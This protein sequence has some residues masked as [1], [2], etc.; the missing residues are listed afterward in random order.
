[1]L[2]ASAYETLAQVINDE[3][4]SPRTLQKTVP[5]DL[6]TICLKCL[7][8]DPQNRY[9][10]AADLAEDLRRFQAGEAIVARPVGP[11]ERAV[12]W[13]RRRPVAAALAVLTALA[14]TAALALLVVAVVTQRQRNEVERRHLEEEQKRLTEERKRQ[15]AELF[16]D[17]VQQILAAAL[18]R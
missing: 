6:E 3:P 18:I 11:S 14:M 4:V 8:K 17:E 2:A 16:L 10:S 7:R 1:F 9:A 5:R 12:K 13:I 15:D